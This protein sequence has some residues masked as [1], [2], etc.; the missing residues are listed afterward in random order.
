[1]LLSLIIKLVNK[2]KISED[3][4]EIIMSIINNKLTDDQKNIISA[5]AKD[6]NI[7][8]YVG[9]EIMKVFIKR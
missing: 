6:S 7:K 3:D 2:S 8:A 4:K 1:M 9:T 5:V